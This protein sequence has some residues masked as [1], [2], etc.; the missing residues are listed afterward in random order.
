MQ[1]LSK[2]DENAYSYAN[3]DEVT[4]DEAQVINVTCKINS[5]FPQPNI[6]I[7]SGSR[8]ISHLFRSS[9]RLVAVQSTRWTPS[10]H[11]ESMAT[12]ASGE[13]MIRYEMN[14]QN[15]TCSALHHGS[16]LP[17]VEI[18]ILIKLDKCRLIVE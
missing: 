3:G 17:P 9:H 6:S 13:L 16:L 5:S 7:W 15:L 1:L 2:D 10:F 14:Q 8:D 12:P 4:F 11:Y 18:S